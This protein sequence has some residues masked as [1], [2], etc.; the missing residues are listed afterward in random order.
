VAMSGPG[1]MIPEQVWD[2]DPIPLR[3]L[4]PGRPSG[5]AMPLVWAHAEYIKLL[6]SRKLGRPYDRPSAT[7]QRYQGLRPSIQKAIW[8]P[9]APL[10]KIRAGQT[11]MVATFGA[12][13]VHWGVDG[14]QAVSDTGLQDIGLGLYAAELDTQP[15]RAGQ[16]IDFTFHGV[17]AGV[18]LGRDYTIAVEIDGSASD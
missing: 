13:T 15:L 6:A 4:Y 9:Q 16:R 10:H 12:G 2:S 3:K 11:L 14:W 18:W 7:W 1:G 8:M 17:G 5:S